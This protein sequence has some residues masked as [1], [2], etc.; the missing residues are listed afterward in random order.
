MEDGIRRLFK[1]CV[2][3]LDNKNSINFIT[4]PDG[5]D[6]SIG[7]YRNKKGEITV[8]NFTLNGAIYNSSRNQSYNAK[9]LKI[10]LSKLLY[11]KK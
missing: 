1:N 4:E 9:T 11:P 7:V 8:V 6:W 2:T 5:A 10:A 3:A